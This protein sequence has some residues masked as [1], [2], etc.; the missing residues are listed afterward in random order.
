MPIKNI[1][2]LKFNRLTVVS[3]LD[4]KD[5]YARWNCVCDCGNKSVVMGIHLRYGNTKSCGCLQKEVTGA[6][7]FKHGEHGTS[8]YVAWQNMIRRCVPGMSYYEKGIE[9]CAH[10]KESYLAFVADMGHRPNGPYS[11][12]RNDP[13][14]NYYKE[15]CQWIL[16][17]ENTIDSYRGK[18]SK[19][20][21]FKAIKYGES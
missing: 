5:G 6:R 21:K 15:N 16:R 20:G 12:E 3:F 8:T 2:G 14:D 7:E 17:I 13:F 18:L 19:R 4:T 11:L 10:W 9:V 1:K